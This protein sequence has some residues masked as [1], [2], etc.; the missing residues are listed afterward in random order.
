MASGEQ[1]ICGKTL[2]DDSTR[3]LLPAALHDGFVAV[4]GFPRPV[5]MALGLME[6]TERPPAAA[7]RLCP[8]LRLP[9]RADYLMWALGAEG[10]FFPP[11]L[12]ELA[13]D[14]L[15]ASALHIIRRWHPQLR[16][17]VSRCEPDLTF[18]LTV[19]TSR[20]MAAWQPSRVTVIG[21]AIHAMKPA[22]GSGANVALR[23]YS[24]GILPTATQPTPCPRSAGMSR[25]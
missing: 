16:E 10:R 3:Q 9:D 2:L 7:A 15:R 17:L 1:L 25:R 18:A 8:D 19:R 11:N 24:A 23:R 14:A 20:E 5:G 13:P 12:R 21:D 4:S 22:G 6:F